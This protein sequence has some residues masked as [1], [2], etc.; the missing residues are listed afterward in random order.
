MA[1]S[2]PDV[3]IACAKPL[4]FV[5]M[6]GAIFSAGP[7]MGVYRMN[8]AC[9]CNMQCADK[10]VHAFAETFNVYPVGA[11]WAPIRPWDG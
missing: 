6:R 9:V 8:T 3:C 11:G 2:A 4:P 7:F 10:A 1:S 5:F